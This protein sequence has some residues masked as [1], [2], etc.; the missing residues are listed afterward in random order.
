LA[1][2]ELWNNGFK[3]IYYYRYKDLTVRLTSQHYIILKIHIFN[4]IFNYIYTN[5]SLKRLADK[6]ESDKGLTT[7]LVHVLNDAQKVTF[8]LELLYFYDSF[9]QPSKWRFY[10]LYPKV[11]NSVSVHSSFAYGSARAQSLQ[12]KYQFVLK[13]E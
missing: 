8:R 9:P 5:D 3:I 6:T 7:F 2:K 12:F 13:F 11:H 10:F 1:E 4:S